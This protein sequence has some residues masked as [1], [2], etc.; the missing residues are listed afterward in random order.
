MKTEKEDAAYEVYMKDLRWRIN[1]LEKVL[2]TQRSENIVVPRSMVQLSKARLADLESLLNRSNDVID[3]S[4]LFPSAAG[5][6]EAN[7][8]GALIRVTL[9]CEGGAA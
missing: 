6:I 7:A 8:V 2:K 9:Q 5:D 3:A 1:E 4:E